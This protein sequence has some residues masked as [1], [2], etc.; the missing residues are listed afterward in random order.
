MQG[1]NIAA[2]ARMRHFYSQD[3]ILNNK[4]NYDNYRAYFDYILI[5]TIIVIV[6]YILLL[7][8]AIT[9]KSPHFLIEGVLFNLVVALL[10][11]IGFTISTYLKN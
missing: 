10:I 5:G 8:M 9:E 2:A 11:V 7:I 6:F 1:L 4:S 3:D